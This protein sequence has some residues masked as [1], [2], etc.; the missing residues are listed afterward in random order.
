MEYDVLK[1]KIIPF[2]VS[3]EDVKNGFLEFLVEGDNTPIDVACEFSNMKVQKVLYPIRCF[4]INYTADWSA[5]SIYEH[6]ESYTEYETKTVYYDRYGKEHDKPGFDYTD[7]SGKWSKSA[8]DS[9]SVKR[10]WQPQQKMVPVT[11]HKMVIDGTEQTYGNIGDNYTF[12]PTFTYDESTSEKFVEWVL[13]FPMENLYIDCK[14]ADVKDCEVEDLVN[15]DL[16]AWQ[17]A[18]KQMKRLAGK[19]AS[20]EVPGDRYEGLTVGNYET[21]HE[22]DVVLIPVFHITYDYKGQAF[23]CWMCGF[24][25]SNVHYENKP[26]DNSIKN[27][28]ERLEKEI[29]D[30]WKNIFLWGAISFLAIPFGFL[31]VFAMFIMNFFNIIWFFVLGY[32]EVKC[33]K[34]F[35]EYLNGRK[36]LQNTKDNY[37]NNVKEKRKSIANIVKREDISEE[38]KRKEI[39]KVLGK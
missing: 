8:M 32:V 15:D 17:I 1:N 11:K 35:K 16:F 34:K 33:I 9:E 38:E 29:K 7:R 5:T 3:N 20:A 13:K 21:E 36:E 18:E 12:Q 31:I 2:D 24:N 19:I 22:V 27:E 30:G 10:P 23:E 4:K 25:D 28:I 39:D 26:K 37:I 6:K 14:E